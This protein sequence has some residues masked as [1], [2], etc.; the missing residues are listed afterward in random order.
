MCLTLKRE[1][2]VTSIL[3][4]STCILLLKHEDEVSGFYVTNQSV[5]MVR[6]S[7]D[8]SSGYGLIHV[9]LRDTKHHRLIGN[10]LT[11]R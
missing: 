11:Q 4:A 7:Q 1:N 8:F 2:E 5:F 3:E 6:Q 9:L 10:K